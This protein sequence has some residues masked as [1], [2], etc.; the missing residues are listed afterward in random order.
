M[1]VRA[2]FLLCAVAVSGF[3]AFATVPAQA[4]SMSECSAKYKEAKTAGTLNGQKWNDFRKAQCGDRCPRPAAAPAAAPPAAPPPAAAEAKPAKPP[5]R[6]RRPAAPVEAGNAVF[7]SAVDPKFASEKPHLARMHTCSEQW[8]AN[9]ANQHHRRHALESEGRRRLLSRMQQAAEGT[10]DRPYRLS[11]GLT[12][13]GIH[14]CHARVILSA[15]LWDLPVE[16]VSGHD[17]P[18]RID[19]GAHYFGGMHSWPSCASRRQMDFSKSGLRRD[20]FHDAGGARTGIGSAGRVF[21]GPGRRRRIDPRGAAD[22]LCGRRARRAC[23][24]RHQRHR[25]R[26]Q[27]RRQFVEP[28]AR[29]HRACGRAR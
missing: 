2:K 1:N 17:C 18:P 9:K 22:G 13:A 4:L 25:G 7:P 28:C 15:R 23:G 26:G 21:A 6:P 14:S 5:K 20:H 3:A 8:K 19:C 11:S 16:H 12:D 24:D 29:R 10:P 27:C